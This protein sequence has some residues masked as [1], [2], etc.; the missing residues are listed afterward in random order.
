MSSANEHD[1]IRILSVAPVSSP[2]RAWYV[3]AKGEVWSRAVVG[4]ATFRYV[5]YRDGVP[6]RHQS[7]DRY[8]G[9]AVFD[10]EGT[11]SVATED[12]DHLHLAVLEEGE[13]LRVVD[14]QIEL[15]QRDGEVSVSPL[16]KERA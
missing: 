6:T 1:V 11:V 16:P 3:D 13:T 2:H 8:Y 12:A 4:L 10:D 9:A 15:V 14:G 7:R 5:T